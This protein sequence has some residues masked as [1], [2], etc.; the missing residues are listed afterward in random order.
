[1]NTMQ[2]LIMLSQMSESFRHE[3]FAQ[4]YH[5]MSNKALW[6]LIWWTYLMGEE[7]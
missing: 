6:N 4:T 5:G 2:R 7:L 3:A 1:M